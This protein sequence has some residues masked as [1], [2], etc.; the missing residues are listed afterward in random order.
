ME[1]P[2]TQQQLLYKNTQSVIRSSKS[3][4]YCGKMLWQELRCQRGR[5]SIQN[6][7]IEFQGI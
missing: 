3:N 2:K 4:D 5:K 7:D 6:S 1:N